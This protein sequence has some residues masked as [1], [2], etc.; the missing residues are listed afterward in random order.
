MGRYWSFIFGADV[1]PDALAEVLRDWGAERQEEWNQWWVYSEV[2]QGGFWLSDQDP[3]MEGYLDRETLGL[4]TAKLGH[5]PLASYEFQLASFIGNSDRVVWEVGL[6]CAERW[7]CVVYDNSYTVWT[8][9]DMAD[10]SQTV[11][12]HLSIALAFAEYVS[13]EQLTEVIAEPGDILDGEHECMEIRRPDAD[14]LILPIRSDGGEWDEYRLNV[15]RSVLGWPTSG[16]LHRGYVGRYGAQQAG[17]AAPSRVSE[18]LAPGAT[19]QGLPQGA[20]PR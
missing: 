9:A 20:Y 19:R 2:P 10:F 17:R 4:V 5:S 1:Q 3:T 8:A 7:P 16:R 11:P 15:I 18:G 6:L 13:V 14:I 12:K